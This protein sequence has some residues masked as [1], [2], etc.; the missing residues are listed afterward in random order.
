MI[1]SFNCIN[2]KDYTLKR[3]HLAY[4][5]IVMPN[6]RTPV[7]FIYFLFFLSLSIFPGRSQQKNIDLENESRGAIEVNGSKLDYVVQGRGPNC[8]II[9]SS[10]YYP[11]TFSEKLRKKLRLIFVDLKWFAKDHVAENITDM[12]LSSIIADVEAIRQEM[13]LEKPIF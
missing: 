12:T 13:G 3:S 1:N 8:L 6:L 10:V 7:T 2:F 5:L 11:K 9:G 4:E